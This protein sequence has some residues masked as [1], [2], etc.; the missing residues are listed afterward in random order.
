LD[1][2]V[3]YSYVR[4]G[5]HLEGDY[6]YTPQHCFV[7]GFQTDALGRSGVVAVPVTRA[8]IRDGALC[9]EF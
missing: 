6:T 9:A 7:K 2:L 5:M 8:M 1:T 3:I 4:E